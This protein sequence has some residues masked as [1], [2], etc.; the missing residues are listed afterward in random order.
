S[1]ERPGAKY[2]RWEMKGVPVRVEIGPRDLKNNVATVVRRDN[3]KKETAPL[4]NI[5]E[6]VRD[7]FRFIHENLLEKAAISLKGRIKDCNTL[8][9]VKEKI[10]EGIARIAWCSERECGLSMEEAVGAAILGIPEGELGRGMGKCP[11]CGRETEN[12]AIMA[13]TY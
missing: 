10:T 1:D 2:Y 9:E 4:A 13:K 8:E 11:A 6:E 12:M 7:R 5:V 3:G